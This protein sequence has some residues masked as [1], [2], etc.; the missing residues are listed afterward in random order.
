MY[1]TD[2]ILLHTDHRPWALPSGSWAY[3]QEWN[4]VLFMHW[5]VP[6]G[7]LQP[8]LPPNL[9]LDLHDNHAWISL[10]P[11]TMNE[12][13]PRRLPAFAPICNFH[14]INV[15]TY[16]TAANKPGV[17]FLSI[18]ASKYLSAFIARQLS[19]LPYEKAVMDR[20]FTH[21]GFGYTS[22]NKRKGFELS[23]AFDVLD[24]IEEKTPL[25]IWLTER[26]C[27]Y[28]STK[29]SLYRYDIHHQP[30]DLRGAN[31]YS[32]T[33]NYKIGNIQ[34]TTPPDLA[35]YSNG[36]QVIAWKRQ[37]VNMIPPS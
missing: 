12:I 34:L 29:G 15:R 6:V 13:R 33:L 37:K 22:I 20:Q 32:L 31:V 16:V 23:T 25:D 9:S 1:S 18:E 30:W 26:Y 36:V 19:G 17:Y 24:P 7:E 2:D 8:L 28:T 4:R 21:V 10:V 3:Y 35:H 11:F 27:L 14:E 5:K